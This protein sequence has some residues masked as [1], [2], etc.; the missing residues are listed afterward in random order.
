MPLWFTSNDGSLGISFSKNLWIINS[1]TFTLSGNPL[2]FSYNVTLGKH[3][4]NESGTREN[5]L[6][7]MISSNNSLKS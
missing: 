1:L 3:P 4:S 6:F 2:F 5:V 7:N